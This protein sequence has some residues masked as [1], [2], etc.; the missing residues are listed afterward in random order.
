MA[1]TE[2]FEGKKKLM[3]ECLEKTLGIVTSAAKMANISRQQHYHWC[4]TFPEYKQAVDDIN[5]VALDF[6]EAQLHQQI[7]AGEVASTIF[8]LKTKGKSRGYVERH[9]ITTPEG[10]T[11]NFIKDPLSGPLPDDQGR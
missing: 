6:A 10:I 7:Q 4:A 1:S 9:E 11:L 3:I 8:Y 5:N 2:N